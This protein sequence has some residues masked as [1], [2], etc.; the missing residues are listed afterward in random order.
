MGKKNNRKRE[1]TWRE[2]NVKKSTVLLLF[3]YMEYKCILIHRSQSEYENIKF[4]HAYYAVYTLVE[5]SIERTQ[6]IYIKPTKIVF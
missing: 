1:S 6:N 2:A 5:V 3:L 4:F